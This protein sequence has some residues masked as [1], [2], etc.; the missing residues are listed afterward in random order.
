M[1]ERYVECRWQCAFNI[2]AM[3]LF[4]SS[5]SE[6]VDVLLPTFNDLAGDPYYMVRRTIA[7]GIHEVDIELVAVVLLIGDGPSV[8]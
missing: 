7:C 2:P 3:F 1:N 6:D 5:A 4:V 8:L